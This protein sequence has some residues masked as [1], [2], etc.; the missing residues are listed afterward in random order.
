MR[1]YDYLTKRHVKVNESSA[2]SIN[3]KRRKSRLTGLISFKFIVQSPLCIYKRNIIYNGIIILILMGPV[4]NGL[5]LYSFYHLNF[6]FADPIKTQ[7]KS[8]RH[9]KVAVIPVL[10]Q[11]KVLQIVMNQKAT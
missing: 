6:I 1:G 8:K 10:N 11:K 7:R 5:L 9:V 2:R 4:I 3:E